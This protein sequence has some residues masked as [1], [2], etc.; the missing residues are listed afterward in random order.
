MGRSTATQAGVACRDSASLSRARRRRPPASISA[1]DLI[2][3]SRL[4]LAGVNGMTDV[5]E[6]MHRNISGLAPIVGPSRPG[7]TRGITGLVYRNIRR[8]SALVGTSLE[9]SLTQLEPLLPADGSSAGRDAARSALNGVLGDYLATTDNPLAIPMQLTDGETPLISGGAPLRAPVPEPSGRVLIMVH[10]LCMND[11]QWCRNDHDHGRAL[12][13]E[14][15]FTPLYL[16]YNSGRPVADNGQDFADLLEQLVH[17][18]PVAVTELVILGHSMGGLV[19][20]SALRSGRLAGHRWPEFLSKMVFLGTPHLGASLERWGTG[21]DTLLGISPYSAPI[22]HIGKVRSAGIRD[23]GEGNIG[24][25]KESSAGEHLGKAVRYFAVAATIR[26]A[27]REGLA[28]GFGDGLVSLRSA[29][30]KHRHRDR[31]LAIPAAHQAIIDQT[32]HFDLLASKR[33]YQCLA[34]WL[35]QGN[36]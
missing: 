6:G 25:G 33:V 1:A 11:R 2:G 16:R 10:G 26:P 9:L 21:L 14:L 19:S 23:L 32:N 22:G 12:A 34:H 27:H 30:G 13:A 15:G 5:V 31:S 35:G 3:T 4:I 8:V 36:P 17:Q 7:P 20:R 18:W 24:G 28:S 29:L